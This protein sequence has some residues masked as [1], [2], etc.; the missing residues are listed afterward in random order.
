MIISGLVVLSGNSCIIKSMVQE[1]SHGLGEGSEE[2]IRRRADRNA[3]V[4]KGFI[5]YE[6][7]RCRTIFHDRQVKLS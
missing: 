1:E 4:R 3:P 2:I 5:L 7:R 6:V